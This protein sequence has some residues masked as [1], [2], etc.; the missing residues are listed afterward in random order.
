MN[1]CQVC[2]EVVTDSTLIE[3]N[4]N[5]IVCKD[6]QFTWILTKN[7]E[8]KYIE[9][10]YLNCASCLKPIQN[11]NIIKKLSKDEIV[12]LNEVL[13]ER[14]IITEKDIYRCPKVDCK[15]A[16]YYNNKASNSAVGVNDNNLPDIE[17]LHFYENEIQCSVPFNCEKCDTKFSV[18]GI[19]KHETGNIILNYII[20]YQYIL[21]LQLSRKCP[22]CLVSINKVIGCD[23]ITCTFCKTEFCYFCGFELR[24]D[25]YNESENFTISTKHN[26]FHNTRNSFGLMVVY[27]FFLTMLKVYFSC[28]FISYTLKLII[29]SII[30]I[31][32]FF[33]FFYSL[34]YYVIIGFTYLYFIRKTRFSNAKFIILFLYIIGYNNLL[35]IFKFVFFTI[36]IKTPYSI[37]YG[38]V[39]LI[40]YLIYYFISGAFS[41]VWF[42]I[43]SIYMIIYYS[44]F[45]VLQIFFIIVVALGLILIILILK[46]KL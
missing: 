22:G 24:N 32:S 27:V 10:N 14:F 37:L 29:T 3:C 28:S 43:H 39:L 12:K 19:N 30:Y 34:F 4:N 18:L 23:H 21:I 35:K 16:G 1:K 40:Y 45:L 17:K 33:S 15:Y 44:F 6:C 8:S 7:D 41:I 46:T 5:C 31:L 2:M 9:N 20:D 42:L 11:E 36:L 26:L 25:R 13:F 38:I